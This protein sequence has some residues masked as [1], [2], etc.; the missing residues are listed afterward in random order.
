MSKSEKI[1]AELFDELDDISELDHSILE[2][3]KEASK[4]KSDLQ[5]EESLAYSHCILCERRFDPKKKQK[6]SAC[7]TR[8]YAGLVCRNCVKTVIRGKIRDYKERAARAGT[9]SNLTNS[10]LFRVIVE[11]A[12]CCSQCGRLCN[13]IH[14][15]H[16]KMTIDHIYPLYLGGMNIKENL[17]VLC[18]RCHE[19][20]DNYSGPSLFASVYKPRV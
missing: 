15:S 19:K 20:K 10:E 5:L 3:V 4:L 18:R 13:N 11:S 2:R 6:F 9:Y 14:S 16:L 12:F 17:A 8:A 1:F 7:S